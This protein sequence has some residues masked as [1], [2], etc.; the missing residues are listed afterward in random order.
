MGLNILIDFDATCVTHG[1]PE[2]GKEIGAVP[3]LKELIDNGHNLILFTMRGSGKLSMDKFGRDGLKDATDWFKSHNIP[4]FG[5]QSHP[6]QGSWT[7]SPKA[8]GDMIIDDTALGIPVKFDAS[9]SNGVF[10]DWIEVRKMLVQRGV[11]PK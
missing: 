11:L 5:I 10:V 7:N 9:L 4:L 2:V 8:H 3:V 6:T 1:Y